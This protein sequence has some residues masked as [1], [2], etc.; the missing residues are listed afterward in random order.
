MSVTVSELAAKLNRE[1]AKENGAE[2]I[3]ADDLGEGE[4]D[5][6]AG[7]SEDADIL[8]TITFL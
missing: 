6:Y 7:D 5:L 1:V 8:A 4:A 3:F 2:E